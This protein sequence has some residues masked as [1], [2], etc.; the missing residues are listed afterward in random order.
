MVLKFSG[1][2]L[3]PHGGVVCFPEGSNPGNLPHVLLCGH[4][5]CGGCLQSL[6]ADGGVLCPDCEVPHNTWGEITVSHLSVLE[7]NTLVK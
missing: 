4:V 2:S 6:E 7:F 5:F 3:V 1:W